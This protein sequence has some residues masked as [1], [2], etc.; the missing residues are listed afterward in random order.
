MKLHI[1]H[2]IPPVAQKMRKTPCHIQKNQEK[3]IDELLSH[4]IIENVIYQLV[5]FLH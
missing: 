3:K 1:D 4:D 2:Q 5:G